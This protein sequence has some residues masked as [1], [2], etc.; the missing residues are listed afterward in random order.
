MTVVD[1]QSA[2]QSMEELSAATVD[3]FTIGVHA[4]LLED[5][6]REIT[7]CATDAAANSSRIASADQMMN[8]I[9]EILNNIR[10]SLNIKPTL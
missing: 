10:A 7:V 3:A 1:V 6:I 2:P 9:E 5:K 8:R 4:R